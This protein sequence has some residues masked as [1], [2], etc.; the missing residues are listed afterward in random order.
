MTHHETAIKPDILVMNDSLISPNFRLYED[1][2]KKLIIILHLVN[3]RYPQRTFS[4]IDVYKQTFGVSHHNWTVFSNV[5]LLPMYVLPQA[6]HCT[7]VIY[8]NF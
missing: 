5:I 3:V 1:T 8:N 7:M 2:I 6:V 4:L